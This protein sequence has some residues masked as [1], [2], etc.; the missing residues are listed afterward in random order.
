MADI[1]NQSSSEEE[2]VE[3]PSR[4]RRPLPSL[5]TVHKQKVTRNKKPRKP[6][7]KTT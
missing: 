2:L 5:I 7:A 1:N 3:T 6:C 4:S